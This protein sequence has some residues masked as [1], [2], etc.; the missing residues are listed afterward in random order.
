LGSGSILASLSGLVL[1][2][3]SIIFYSRKAKKLEKEYAY[4]IRKIVDKRFGSEIS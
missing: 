3:G 4:S 2:V 1:S